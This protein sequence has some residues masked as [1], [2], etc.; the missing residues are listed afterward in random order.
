MHR[1][2]QHIYCQSSV[3]QIGPGYG[4]C[5]LAFFW[6]SSATPEKLVRVHW[7]RM[8]QFLGSCESGSVICQ[9]EKCEELNVQCIGQSNEYF[10]AKVMV[11]A[12]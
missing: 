3:S 11:I 9:S 7:P 5:L 10:M 8:G 12:Y 4:D 6:G 1:D 2:A